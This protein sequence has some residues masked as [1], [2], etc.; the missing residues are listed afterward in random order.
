MKN[1]KFIDLPLRASRMSFIDTQVN[2]AAVREAEVR[3]ATQGRRGRRAGMR[4]RTGS[5]AEVAPQLGLGADQAGRSLV[6]GAPRRRFYRELLRVLADREVWGVRPLLAGLVACALTMVVLIW[7]VS[8]TMSGLDATVVF[9][10]GAC[11][12]SLLMISLCLHA[13]VASR[14]HQGNALL[15]MREDDAAEA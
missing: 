15:K 6:S 2:D 5:V 4:E 12:F 3:T 1:G 10:L 11:G 14:G 13:A 7:R 8:L 9:A